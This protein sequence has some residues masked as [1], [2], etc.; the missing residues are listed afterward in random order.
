MPMYEYAIILPD[1]TDGEIFGHLQSFDEEPLTA[2]P[3]D[4]RP[5]RRI[6]SVPGAKTGSSLAKPDMSSKNLERLGFTQ[7]KKAGGG[8]YKKTACDGP[9]SI[10]RD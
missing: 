7:Y 5:V 8:K 2:H 10:S 3:V 1:G 6:F 4:G 9:G